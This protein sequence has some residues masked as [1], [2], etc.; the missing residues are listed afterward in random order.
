MEEA[1]SRWSGKAE[2]QQLMLMDADLKLMRNDIDGALKVLSSVSPTQS[3]YQIARIKMAQIYLEEKKDKRQ[4]AICYKFLNF[5][6][7]KGF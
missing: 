1:T 2:E 3:N 5:I 6:F 7:K 4:F